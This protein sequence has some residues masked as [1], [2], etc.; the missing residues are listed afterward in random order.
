[1]TRALP[2]HDAFAPLAVAAFSLFVMIT[3]SCAMIAVTHAGTDS[4]NH[5]PRARITPTAHAI[6]LNTASVVELSLLPRVGG[7]LAS[8]ITSDRVQ[9][10]NFTSVA[11]LARVRGISSAIIDALLEHATVDARA[12]DTGEV[13]VEQPRTTVHASDAHDSNTHESNTHDSNTRD[14]N[15]HESARAIRADGNR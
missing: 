8:R 2:R 14:S 10:G 3:A 11:D 6:N 15:T 7:A 9:N 4:T 1:M 5:I 12:C 13:V